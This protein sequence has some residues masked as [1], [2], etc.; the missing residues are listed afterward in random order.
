MA[1]STNEFRAHVKELSTLLK[2]DPK[3]QSCLAEL[4][5]EFALGR[6]VGVADRC[7][8]DSIAKSAAAKGYR[9]ADLIKAVVQSKVFRYQSGEQP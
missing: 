9:G 8:I 6:V 4:L 5:S 1:D 2:G 7:A 3:V